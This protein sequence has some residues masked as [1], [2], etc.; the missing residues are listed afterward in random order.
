MKN[1]LLRT[2]A[3]YSL[4]IIMFVLSMDTYAQPFTVAS[5]NIRYNNPGDSLNAWPLRKEVV[6]RLINFHEID[7]LG[8][9][10]ALH[11]Q[12]LDLAEIK[13]FAWVGV[14]R[15]DGKT[16]GEYSAIFYD[17]TVFE[18]IESGTFWLSPT[19]D[20]VS[21]GWDADLERICTW[22]K[23]RHIASGQ[24]FFH[25]NTHFDHRGEQARQES[26]KLLVA[27]ATEMAGS[28][29]TLITGDFNALPASIAIQRMTASFIDSKSVSKLAPYGPEG[30]TNSFDYLHP[31][32]KRID[33]IFVS[34]AVKVLKYGVLTDHY[35]R[36]YPSDHLPVVAKVGF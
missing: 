30:T 36:R 5:Y 27:K 1:V 13:R 35:D 8:V 24:V 19:P 4:G 2:H 9:Q 18:A 6:R 29:P 17:K 16:K 14:G 21:K 20:R 7:L 28:L 11:D 32:D 33:Y 25:F 26:A 12:I 10:E 15:D 31:L 23:F 22:A 34:R 3:M